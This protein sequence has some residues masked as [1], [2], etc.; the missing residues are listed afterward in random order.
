L[1]PENSPF[2]PKLVKSIKEIQ[3]GNNVLSPP[4]S[5]TSPLIDTKLSSA[6]NYRMKRGNTYT[7]DLLKTEFGAE[8]YDKIKG[9]PSTDIFEKHK[10]YNYLDLVKIIK[11]K[12][13]NVYLITYRGEHYLH[14]YFKGKGEATFLFNDIG[15]YY[16]IRT[17]EDSSKMQVAVNDLNVHCD[18]SLLRAKNFINDHSNIDGFI[19]NAENDYDIIIKMCKM[20][21][22]HCKYLISYWE[23]RDNQHAPA[24]FV[25]LKNK[26][27]I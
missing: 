8:R 27:E 21:V 19:T 1:A 12:Q 6:E 4:A 9:P 3:S 17:V 25:T 13:Y 11:M 16:T 23:F 20:I 24:S 14:Q 2:T 26:A 18:K 7:I 15:D 10:K 5:A 22:H